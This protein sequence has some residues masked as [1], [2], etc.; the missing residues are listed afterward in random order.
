MKFNAFDLNSNEYIKSFVCGKPLIIES[1]NVVNA[2]KKFLR[3][4]AMSTG[5]Y[6]I[7][8]STRVKHTAYIV[9]SFG[10]CIGLSPAKEG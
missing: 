9:S 3:E 10:T 1:N 8:K 2:C 7:Q 6:E 4:N 5:F